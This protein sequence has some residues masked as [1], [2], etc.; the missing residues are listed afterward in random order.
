MFQGRAA[1][2]TSWSSMQCTSVRVFLTAVMSKIE[3]QY[4]VKL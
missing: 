3:L 1:V 4:L 2:F